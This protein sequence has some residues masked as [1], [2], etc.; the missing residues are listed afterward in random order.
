MEIQFLKQTGDVFAPTSRRPSADLLSCLK[1]ELGRQTKD[2]CLHEPGMGW[3]RVPGPGLLIWNGRYWYAESA[4][5]LGAIHACAF[6]VCRLYEKDYL[7]LYK[8]AYPEEEALSISR[9]DRRQMARPASR[10]DLWDIID[11]L[12]DCNFSSLVD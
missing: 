2:A 9:A 12:R 1:A 5:S 10:D 8:S 11:D 3:H 6:D 4:C 7:A